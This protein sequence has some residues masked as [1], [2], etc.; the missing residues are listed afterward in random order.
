MNG[1][2]DFL[3]G[4]VKQLGGQR[5]TDPGIIVDSTP[6]YNQVVSDKEPIETDKRGQTIGVLNR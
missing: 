3:T 5:F 1:L 6:V 2:I 4:V